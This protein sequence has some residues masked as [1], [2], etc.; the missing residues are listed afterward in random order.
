MEGVIIFVKL[1]IEILENYP[2]FKVPLVAT[3]PHLLTLKRA[4]VTLMVSRSRFAHPTRHRQSFRSRL[5]QLDFHRL[6]SLWFPWKS[7]WSES[8]GS[9]SRPL[10]ISLRN[11]HSI[12]SHAITNYERFDHFQ[13]EP[14]PEMIAFLHTFVSWYFGVYIVNSFLFFCFLQFTRRSSDFEH[15]RPTIFPRLAMPNWLK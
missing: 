10:L 8:A 6:I 4:V 5:D 3:T 7:G 13:I 2:F 12:T 1:F 14:L 15:W 11:F 9:I